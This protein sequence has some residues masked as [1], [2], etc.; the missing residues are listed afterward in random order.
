M[1]K[2][3]EL[4]KRI[5]FLQAEQDAAKDLIEEPA[6]YKRKIE[7]EQNQKNL[8]RLKRLNRKKKPKTQPF[9]KEYIPFLMN[10]INCSKHNFLIKTRLRVA[11]IC[12]IHSFIH[13]YWC[14]NF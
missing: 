13:S 11:C 14:T 12:L 3:N 2:Q 8:R 10:T 4:L 1:Q 7:E 9:L 5:Q 6:E